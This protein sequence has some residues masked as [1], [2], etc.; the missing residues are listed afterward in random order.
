VINSQGG[1]LLYGGLCG[2]RNPVIRSHFA[3]IVNIM[4]TPLIDLGFGGALKLWPTSDMFISSLASVLLSQ[5]MTG[6][7]WQEYTATL[8]G[9]IG[10]ATEAER[11]ETCCQKTSGSFAACISSVTSMIFFP[12]GEVLEIC[13]VYSGAQALKNIRLK[14]RK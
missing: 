12:S 14:S 1:L 7:E 5:V 10:F 9:T 11:T 8:P 2:D 6:C 13:P 4:D 3:L